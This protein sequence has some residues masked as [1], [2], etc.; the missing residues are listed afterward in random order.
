MKET[1]CTRV[2]KSVVM[3]AV[4]AIAAISFSA[5]AYVSLFVWE[6]PVTIEVVTP[7]LNVY[8]DEECTEPVSE[9]DL[10][11][12][13]AGARVPADGVILYI[14]NEGDE[15]LRLTWKSTAA[16]ETDN[17]IWNY[18]NTN[19]YVGNLEGRYI[20][21]DEVIRTEYYIQASPDSPLEPLSWKI[22]LGVRD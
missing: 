4:L 7:E 8:F 19:P 1:S 15:R 22:Y 2:R 13:Q 10:G 18:W 17:K 3:L 5:Y 20:D 21:P 6:S 12:I 16:S 9:I 14:R 11:T